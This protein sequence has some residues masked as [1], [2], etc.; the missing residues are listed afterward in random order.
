MARAYR[1]SVFQ[2]S[3]PF[4]VAMKLLVPTETMVKGVRKTVYSEPAN[5][6]QFFGNFKTYGGTENFSNDV[7]TIYDTAII[8]TWY[9]PSI[10]S[11]CKIYICES[12]REYRIISEPE[13]IELRHQYM[14]FKVER[15]GGKP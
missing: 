7:Y 1:R 9:N 5:S 14:K 3:S 4:S 11:D 12:G 10:T 15:I 6:F 2:P 8:E 13:D